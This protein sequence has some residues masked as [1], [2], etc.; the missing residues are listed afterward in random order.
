MAAAY[1]SISAWLNFPSPDQAKQSQLWHRDPEDLKLMKIFIYLDEVDANRGPFTYIPKSHPF[2]S[3]SAVNPQHA[4]PKR[5]TDDEMRAAIPAQDWVACTGPAGTT[6][7]ADT[8]GFHRG[9]KPTIGNRILI[10]FTYTSGTPFVKSALPTGRRAGLGLSVRFNATP[11]FLQEC[12]QF[13]DGI[14]FQRTH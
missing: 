2:G 5:I 7:L 6:I 11:F 13:Q 9:G 12:R 3:R 4:D 8:V 14:G 10:T 1:K